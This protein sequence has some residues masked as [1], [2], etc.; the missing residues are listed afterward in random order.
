MFSLDQQANDAAAAELRALLAGMRDAFARG[1]NAME[2]AR[3]VLG[4]NENLSAATLIAYD[5]QAGAYV[6]HALSDPDGKRRWCSQL[7]GLVAAH[8]PSGGS[9]MEVGSGEATTL[10]GLLEALPQHP[11]A[12]LGFDISWSRCA[13]GRGWLR[14]KAQHAELFVADLFHI[15][16]AD[17]SV[18]VVYT[19]HSLEPNG[20]REQAALQEL[21]RVARRAVVLVEPIY[22][23]AGPDARE[24]MAH[25]GYVRNLKVTAEALGC[26]VADYRL[27]DFYVNPLNP[28]GVVCIVKVD[29]CEPA[30]P[31]WR[32]PL[33]HAPLVRSESAFSSPETGLVYPVL[34]GIPLLCR[35]HAVLA[36]AYGQSIAP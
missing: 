3:R 11:G 33:T 12:A 29:A 35:D 1:E 31:A 19:S 13:H 32:C 2:Y 14:H 7:A 22:E 25:H 17:A 4:R 34:D 9:V 10:A 20:G 28:S 23:L 21:L 27:L 18:D 16:L 6:R 8:L 15:P 26:A 30:P 24:R 36:S 5:L